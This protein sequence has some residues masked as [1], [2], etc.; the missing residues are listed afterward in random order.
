MA[1]RQFNDTI[2][3]VPGIDTAIQVLRPG[4]KWDLLN[5]TFIGWDDPENREPPTWDELQVE[6][7]RQYEI[8]EYF[9][10]ERKRDKEY[11]SIKDQLDMLYHDIE[12]GN[13]SDGL[14]ISVIKEVKNKN[15]KPETP[16]PEI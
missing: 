15:P 4:A 10:Y 2:Y 14:W 3:P 6:L 16:Q 1:F 9:E 12:S 13:L 7:R 5:Q 11:P 8:Y